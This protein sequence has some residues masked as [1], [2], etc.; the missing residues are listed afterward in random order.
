[1][2]ATSFL[3]SAATLA[4]SIVLAQFTLAQ[5][6]GFT[7][8]G[9]LNDTSAPAN[10]NYDLRLI[11]Y[12][13]DVGGSQVGPILT[14]S[15]V[16]VT[17]G[18]FNLRLDFGAGIFTGTNHFLEIAVRTNGNGPFVTLSPRQPLSPAPYAIMANNASNLLGTL[19]VAQLSGT[20]P[21]P[22]LSGAYSNALTFNNPNNAFSGSG[23]NL[24]GLNA[25]QLAFGTVADARLSANVALR[26]SANTFVGNQSVTSGN[27]GI[28][29]VPISRLHVNGPVLLQ[30]GFTPTASTTSNM[31]NLAV[32]V[33]SN[34][35][36]NGIAFYES[37]GV[38]AMSLGYD[39][40]VPGTANNALRI[41]D[42]T[43]A[44]IFSFLHGGSMGIGT[45]APASGLHVKNDLD[46]EVSIESSD[47]GGHRWTIQS[48]RVSGNTHLDASFQIIDRTANA[49][50]V[51]I[52]TN[53]NV[54]IHT[55][56]PSTTLDVNGT[57]TTSDL[58]VDG[59]A[60]RTYGSSL[61]RMHPIAYGCVSSSGSINSGTGNFSVTHSI[62]T[63][64]YTIGISGETY[65]FIQYST[66]VTPVGL[67]A[68]IPMTFSSSG[69]L[70]VRLFNISGAGVDQDFDFV[71]YKPG[72]N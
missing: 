51:L 56:A 61:S 11:L 72:S 68:T 45:T 4:G 33:S 64:A 9:R 34:G 39:G 35:F 62:G 57:T 49:S 54:G 14:N 10:G 30:G 65:S 38:Q 24:T 59:D 29:A 7:Y 20:L 1:M 58:V 60:L 27:V 19:A 23:T 32:G 21:S 55:T 15:A 46:T 63:G 44:P 26:N 40:S 16:S 8:Q 69:S 28:N 67:S 17:G 25:S 2:K 71:V 36:A 41:Y 43:G 6:T 12:N 47:T 66:I 31:L 52:A 37:A 70:Q 3:I 50:R 42:T 18:L 48:S 13:A 53:G 22:N 5:G